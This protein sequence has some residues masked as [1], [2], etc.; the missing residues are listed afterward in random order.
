MTINGANGNVA[1]ANDIVAQ[2]NTIR[3]TSTGTGDNKR[4]II[5]LV[6]TATV[7]PS[8]NVFYVMSD[9]TA[10]CTINKGGTLFAT[11]YDLDSLPELP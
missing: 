8:S 10:T 9:G 6:P 1:C 2:G 3:L 11:T 5:Q 4:G 7:Q